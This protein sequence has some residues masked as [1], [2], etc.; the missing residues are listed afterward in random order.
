MT[1][2]LSRQICPN[3]LRLLVPDRSI[4]KMPSHTSIILKAKFSDQPS[5]YNQLLDI[6]RNFK[7]QAIDAQGAIDR[8]SVLLT[9]HRSLLQV[10]NTFLPARHRIERSQDGLTTTVIVPRPS[11]TT[12]TAARPAMHYLSRCDGLNLT[13]TDPISPHE[14]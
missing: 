14:T 2:K 6:M 3:D 1:P 7:S 10:F 11:G 5:V 9:G 4:S 8:V 12:T 13:I